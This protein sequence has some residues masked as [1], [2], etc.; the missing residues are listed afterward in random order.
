MMT[1]NHRKLVFMVADGNPAAFPVIH[2]M[3]RLTRRDE[4]YAWLVRNGITGD[5]FVQFVAER[6]GSLV[7]L[8]REILSRIDGAAPSQ[9]VIGKDIA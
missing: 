9:M 8:R 1:G 5:K 7:Q 3:E 2:A 4:I 6:R